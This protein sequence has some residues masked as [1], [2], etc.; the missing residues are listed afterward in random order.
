MIEG[1]RE[2]EK[3]RERGREMEEASQAAMDVVMDESIDT[4]AS[5]SGGGPAL[6]EDVAMGE[7]EAVATALPVPIPLSCASIEALSQ[8]TATLT[9]G[10]ATGGYPLDELETLERCISFLSDT[11]HSAAEASPQV[12]ATF[13]NDVLPSCVRTLMERSFAVDMAER[14]NS[15]IKEFIQYLVT[16][17]PELRRSYYELL[18]VLLCSSKGGFYASCGWESGEWT[19]DQDSPGAAIVKTDVKQCSRFLIENIK[20]FASSGGISR[21]TTVLHEKDVPIW[22][23]RLLLQPFCRMRSMLEDVLLEQLV[24]SWMK[25][26]CDRLLE[27]DDDTMKN[28]QRDDIQNI[29][30]YLRLLAHEAGSGLRQLEFC[31]LELAMKFLK[32]GT[33]EKR[34]VGL[35]D[36]VAVAKNLVPSQPTVPTESEIDSEP[37]LITDVFFKNW[38]RQENLLELLFGESSHPQIMSRTGPILLFLAKTGNLLVSDLDLVW[39]AGENKHESLVHIVYGLFAE[40]CST[41]QMEHIEYLFAAK[42]QPISPSEFDAP[43][44]TLLR[45]LSLA[46]IPL[47][48]SAQNDLDDGDAT[49]STRFF[50]IHFAWEM[51]QDG[52]YERLSK[53]NKGHALAVVRDFLGWQLCFELRELFITRC[54]ANLKRFAT[55]SMSLKVT[56]AALGTHAQEGTAGA[57][58]CKLDEEQLFLSVIFHALTEYKRQALAAA[59]EL[60]QEGLEEGQA[61]DCLCLCGNVSHNETMQDFLGLLEFILTHSSLVLNTEQIDSLWQSLV[62]NTISAADRDRAFV[63]LDSLLRNAKLGHKPFSN[64]DC[65]YILLRKIPTLDFKTLSVAGYNLLQSYFY[66]ANLNLASLPQLVYHSRLRA[67]AEA[68]NTNEREAA[69][70]DQPEE[71]LGSVAGREAI[72]AEEEPLCSKLIGVEIVWQAALTMVNIAASKT[73][74]TFL[75]SLYQSPLEVNECHSHKEHEVFIKCCFSWMA[76]PIMSLRSGTAQADESE[77]ECETTITR[78]LLL[79]KNLV[80][81]HA[82]L[83]VGEVVGH[84]AITTGQP[85]TIKAHGVLKNVPVVVHTNDKLSV[86][87]TKLAELLAVPPARVRIVALGKELRVMNKTISQ[88]G[89]KND[90]SI[91]VAL[92]SVDDSAAGTPEQEAEVPP[93][94][95]ETPRHILSRPEYFQQLFTMLDLT[96]PVAQ[97]TWDLLMLLPTNQ[98]MLSN[99]RSDGG[100][101]AHTWSRALDPRSAFKLLYSLQIVQSVID[102][103]LREEEAHWCSWFVSNGGVHHLI[104]VLTSSEVSLDNSSPKRRICMVHI[105]RVIAQFVLHARVD[106]GGLASPKPVS[107]LEELDGGTPT[108]RGDLLVSGEKHDDLVNQLMALCWRTVPVQTKAAS[109]EEIEEVSEIVRLTLL[110]LVTLCCER[111]KALSHLL[112]H[113]NLKE[114]LCRLVCTTTNQRVRAIAGDAVLQLTGSRLP[115]EL[116]HRSFAVF[117]E[118]LLVLLPELGHDCP[119]A[120]ECYSIVALLLEQSFS[121]TDTPASC[122]PATLLHQLLNW[123][124]VHKAVEEFDTDEDPVLRGSLN[125]LRVLMSHPALCENSALS[126]EEMGVLVEFLFTKCLFAIPSAAQGSCDRGLPLCKSPTTRSA[127]FELLEEIATK[128]TLGMTSLL[129]LLCAQHSCVEDRTE[130]QY[131]PSGMSKSATGFVGLVNQGATCYM[132]SLLQ[133][134]F[135]TQGFRKDVLKLKEEGKSK[136]E[137]KE[138]VLHQVQVIFAG[139]QESNQRAYDT[140]GLCKAFKDFEGNPVNPGLQMDADEFCNM[141]FDKLE[142]AMKDAGEENF[143]KKHFGGELCNQ[144][145]SKDCGHISE[146]VEPFYSISV[147]VK[148]KSTLDTSL[149]LYVE[150][151]MLEGDNKYHCSTCD[152]KVVAL[153]R[154]CVLS[155]PD[156]L[157]IHMRRF[158]FNFEHMRRMKVNDLC[159][160]PLSLDMEPYTKQGLGHSDSQPLEAEAKDLHPPSYF[161]YELVGVLVHTGTADSGHY[162]SF[163]KDR[164]TPAGQWYQ[165]N[166][167]SVDPWNRA[168][169][170]FECFGGYET[171]MQYDTTYQKQMPRQR[172]RMNNAYMLVYE[173]MASKD[174]EEMAPYRNEMLCQLIWSENERFWRDKYLFDDQ[175][176]SFMASFGSSIAPRTDDIGLETIQMAT[177]YFLDVL[178]RAKEE[179]T[180]GGFVA[181][182]K[183][184]YSRSEQACSWFLDTT[185]QEDWIATY[186]LKCHS[187]RTRQMVAGLVVHALG[188]MATTTRQYLATYLPSSTGIAAMNSFGA[189]PQSDSVPSSIRYLNASINMLLDGAET[190]WRR[191]MQFFIPLRAFCKFGDLERQ[192]LLSVSLPARL[193]HFYLGEKSPLLAIEPGTE[194]AGSAPLLK[195]PS[196][197]MGDRF[198]T[199]RV[200]PLIDIVSELARCC[201]THAPVSS[202]ASPF[203]GPPAVSHV[204]KE[205]NAPQGEPASVPEPPKALLMGALDE[206]MIYCD[207]FY[208]RLLQEGVNVPASL[209]L[210]QHL[211]WEDQRFSRVLLDVITRGMSASD[212]EAQESLLLAF[213]SVLEVEDEFRAWRHS[214]GLQAFVRTVETCANVGA[215]SVMVKFIADLSLESQLT[216]DWLFSNM[217]LWVGPWLIAHKNDEVRYKCQELLQSFMEDVGRKDKPD[218]TPDECGSQDPVEPKR[219]MEIFL[220]LLGLLTGVARYHLAETFFSFER[221]ELQAGQMESTSYYATVEKR[222]SPWKLV[223]YF[224][225]MRE[226][227]VND[228]FRDV[229]FER[230]WEPLMNLFFELDQLKQKNDYNKREFILF[231][232]WC[233]EAQSDCNLLPCDIECPPGAPLAVQPSIYCCYLTRSSTLYSRFLNYQ[234]TILLQDDFVR[235]NRTATATFY[236]VVLRCCLA[237]RAFLDATL[238]H[239]NLHWSLESF[240]FSLDYP[241][242]SNALFDI[243]RLGTHCSSDFSKVVMRIAITR[244]PDRLSCRRVVQSLSLV[245]RTEDDAKRFCR[246]GGPSR[247]A[248]APDLLA[249]E[250]KTY[251]P[252][253]VVPGTFEK[254]NL[255]AEELSRIAGTL[256]VLWN[257][258]EWLGYTQRREPALVKEALDC[259]PDRH[260]LLPT[261]CSYLEEIRSDVVLGLTYKLL[262]VLCL[263]DRQYLES[264]VHLVHQ[265]HVNHSHACG[266]ISLAKVGDV[267]GPPKFKVHLPEYGSQARVHEEYY[268]FLRRLCNVALIKFV[269]TED[270]AR[271]TL[272]VV[273]LGVLESTHVNSAC[274][275]MCEVLVSLW[276][277]K[278]PMRPLL[279]DHPL[280]T[281]LVLRAFTRDHRLLDL[282]ECMRLVALAFGSAAAKLEEDEK[283]T[284]MVSISSRLDA[285]MQLISAP[286]APASEATGL[287]LL[288]LLKILTMTARSKYFRANLLQPNVDGVKAVLVRAREV[289]ATERHAWP[290]DEIAAHIV[291]LT[292]Q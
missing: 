158:E 88:V 273:L 176:F 110:L 68:S 123:V 126:D 242:V 224:E 159:D 48:A 237:S 204:V 84:G 119:T 164:S 38:I 76:S 143:V 65:L 91:I 57:L 291:S 284:L 14:V 66:H 243:I 166:D 228:S 184:L 106:D 223:P 179:D 120:E 182:L 26:V 22:A 80:E 86:L 190:H 62:V 87:R 137:L 114:W 148:G 130:W 156:T 55:I 32:R 140:I 256:Q 132:N 258:I 235:F 51:L 173:R 160:F 155:L 93:R 282:D 47:K 139:L 31:S 174:A 63:W 142:T 102:N 141:L 85:I 194:T 70:A 152:S 185:I 288:R 192:Y 203:F 163:I 183:K 34:L 272:N 161:K 198:T 112:A 12:V 197:V 168:N 248:S 79:L 229:L 209:L 202:G 199:P 259:W 147:A 36:I 225:L 206:R 146:T 144:V 92:K 232:D 220:H 23:V 5:A 27:M 98:E 217:E 215:S 286:E 180:I 134:L 260:A 61:L 78:T 281:A 4:P 167:Q 44:F 207:R 40:I 42:I 15:F 210:I 35:A 287:E 96:A 121:M 186:L 103:E 127:A 30:I 264:V 124:F 213:A 177:N 247:I 53:E 150:G 101:G 214:H 267:T 21:A 95:A 275:S 107:S 122:R 99:L 20:A 73:A 200:G 72:A 226:C 151:D 29:K 117:F 10:L 265:E 240:Y 25:V 162:Y 104:Q 46:A 39:A 11:R 246:L 212:E 268:E 52:N 251:G 49:T 113:Q 245:V 41:L 222:C 75:S 195:R 43:T 227:V 292:T 118:S 59:A 216:R 105:L 50:G 97:T 261:L 189:L 171:V 262:K 111:E 24:I 274:R 77:A 115:Q 7:A 263:V 175:Y 181:N 278:E 271:L 18:T 67:A 8:E 205:A 81:G 2:R 211:A 60:Q 71:S 157:I 89:I 285:V 3:E 58:L 33:L 276:N 94:P 169:L 1:D 17:L 56:M 19:E 172:E 201:M 54:I 230:H 187:S 116:G 128:S 83:E 250:N 239:A 131:S 178:C 69:A 191:F 193:I 279:I 82:A 244:S 280:L 257:G 290:E 16:L 233:L 133:Q 231:L 90:F 253:E 270:Q 269:S 13:V 255:S 252:A 165:F 238:S 28:A 218:S 135:M 241:E 129:S 221:K 45:S 208:L 254:E 145:I 219:T 283:A 249:L 149:E 188:A 266:G 234:L 170:A 153:K 109:E 100:T 277:S 64:E 154:C 125:L 6:E 196:V 236:R 37:K 138:S 289:F 9:H 108:L 136:E 74:M